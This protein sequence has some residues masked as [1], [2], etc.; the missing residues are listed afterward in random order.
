MSARPAAGQAGQAGL[1]HDA[2]YYGSDEEF[3]SLVVPFLIGGLNAGQPTFAVFAEPK[4]ALLRDALPDPS[5][6]TFFDGEVQYDRPATTLRNYRQLMAA[7]VAAGARQVRVAG[8]VPYPGVREP[9]SGWARYEAAL[10]HVFAD[11]PAWALCPY[12]TRITP[13]YVLAD[14]ARTH[15]RLVTGGKQIVSADYL[16]PTKFLSNQNCAEPEL[17]PIEDSAPVMEM[18]DPPTGTARRVVEAVALACGLLRDEVDDLVAA[19]HEAITNAFIHGQRPVRLRVWAGLRRVVVAVTDRGLGPSDP[20]AGL[21]PAPRFP[22]EGL[23]LW[24]IHQL[25]RHVTMSRDEHGF[26]IR[27]VAGPL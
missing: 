15:P 4:T 19:V 3:L 16:E 25:C 14:V 5:A 6:V 7:Q 12:D 13:D 1:I 11:F 20:F 27:L 10:N 8:G 18:V 9:W 26:T 17:D 22:D 24:L 23:G 2:G 21:L